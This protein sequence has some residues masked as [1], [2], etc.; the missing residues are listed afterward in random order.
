MKEL[1]NLNPLYG[2]QFKTMMN[3]L[4]SGSDL[5]DPARL[6]DIGATL[7]T[8]DEETLQACVD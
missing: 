1:V 5:N 6:T 8:A 4:G 3:M 7:T 2:E